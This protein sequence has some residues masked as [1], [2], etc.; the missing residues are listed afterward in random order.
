MPTPHDPIRRVFSPGPQGLPE[1]PN[2]RARQPLRAPHQG[3]QPRVGA[4]AQLRAQNHRSGKLA[5][6]I[7][8]GV[9][10]GGLAGRGSW[11]AWVLVAG[12]TGR[13]KGQLRVLAPPRS[14]GKW[15]VGT[16]TGGGTGGGVPCDLD[17]GQVGQGCCYP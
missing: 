9:T 17:L 6:H 15:A 2:A 10:W 13:S 8:L 4:L 14:S 3:T 5:A 11:V 16:G 1:G 7:A 12:A